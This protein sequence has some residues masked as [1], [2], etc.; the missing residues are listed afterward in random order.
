MEFKALNDDDLKN[1]SGGMANPVAG[2]SF[3]D[4]MKRATELGDGQDMGD[5]Q[6]MADSQFIKWWRESNLNS[7]EYL[8]HKDEVDAF[9]AK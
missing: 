9:I 4:A 3:E 7:K 2:M 5:W 8:D 6:T 1:V